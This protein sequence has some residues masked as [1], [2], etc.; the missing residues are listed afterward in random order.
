MSNAPLFSVIIPTYRRLGAI[1]RAIESVIAQSYAFWEIIVVERCPS[2]GTDDL[3]LTY[4]E[5]PDIKY[6]PVS[7]DFSQVGAIAYQR[8]YGIFCSRGDYL[9]FLDSDDWW[10]PDK[11]SVCASNLTSDCDLLHHP[12]IPSL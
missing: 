5:Y 12:N 2:D 4:S 1:R 6:F 3:L 8:N 11:L 10:H 9:A 7:H